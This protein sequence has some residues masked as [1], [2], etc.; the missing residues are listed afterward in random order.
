MLVVDAT[1]STASDRVKI[2][3][4]GVQETSFSQADYPNQNITYPMFIASGSNYH[5]VGSAE[6]GT[7]CWD[8]VMSHVHLCDGTALAPTVFGSTDSTTGE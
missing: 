2:Y 5:T 6:N 8:G 4:N 1:Q 7:D 3:V